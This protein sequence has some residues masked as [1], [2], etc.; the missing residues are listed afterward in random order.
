LAPLTTALATVPPELLPIWIS[1]AI[2]LDT[3]VVE[4]GTKINS[5][6]NPCFL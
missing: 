5:T 3:A 1:P 6:S 2:I 4:L